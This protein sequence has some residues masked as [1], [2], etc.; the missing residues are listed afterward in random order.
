MLAN[1]VLETE[2][3]IPEVPKCTRTDPLPMNLI[4]TLGPSG[5]GLWFGSCL[6]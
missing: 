1:C 3:M 6:T 4:L 5:M 2:I